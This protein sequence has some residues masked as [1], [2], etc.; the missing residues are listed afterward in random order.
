LESQNIFTLNGKLI[1]SLEFQHI[2]A[3]DAIPVHIVDDRSH[4]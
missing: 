1:G 3:W 4:W 2:L